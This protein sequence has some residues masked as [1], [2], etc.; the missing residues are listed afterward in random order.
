M[1]VFEVAVALAPLV[2]GCEEYDVLVH[3]LHDARQQL[4]GPK[5]WVPSLVMSLQLFEVSNSLYRQVSLSAHSSTS[6]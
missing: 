2:R 3:L 1:A 5:D 6:K 4:Y